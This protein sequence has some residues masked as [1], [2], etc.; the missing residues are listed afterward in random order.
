M[1]N[2][3]SKFNHLG[4]TLV[5]LMTGIVIASTLLG[6]GVPSFFN[7]IAEN[8][9]A[10][11]TNELI[12]SMHYARSEAVRREIPVS[13]CASV[14]GQSCSGDT[15]WGKGWIAFTDENGMNGELDAGDDLI[16][17]NQTEGGRIRIAA[18]NAYVRYS[19]RGRSI[20]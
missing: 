17:T 8:R 1:L 20:N 19:P 15:E 12:A 7:L 11:A 6:V 10:V 13:I 18:E 3:S 5:E 2:R 9:L 16:F 14:D 4:L